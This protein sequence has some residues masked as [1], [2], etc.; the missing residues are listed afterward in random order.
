MHKTHCVVTNTCVLYKCLLVCNCVV[1]NLCV[2]FKCLLGC[3]SVVTNLCVL[4]LCY[5]TT[6]YLRVTIQ[7]KCMLLQ[8]LMS[9]CKSFHKIVYLACLPYLTLSV[10]R[11]G[12]FLHPAKICK[13]INPDVILQNIEK[14]YRQWK[15]LLSFY[16][17]I[18]TVG[19]HPQTQKVEPPC[20]A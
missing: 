15:I 8:M 12:A 18:Y 1:T 3:N 2:V 13:N 5:V 10:T 6:V 11:A 20:T 17:N 7:H 4:L 19:F 14:K 16:F 9:V